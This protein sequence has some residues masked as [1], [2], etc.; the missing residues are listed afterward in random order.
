MKRNYIKTIL[1]LSLLVGTA[2]ISSCTKNFDEMNAPWKDAQTADINSLFNGVVASIELGAQEQATANTWIYPITQL[3]T[4]VSS[5][6]YTMQNASNELWENYYRALISLRQI[7]QMINDSPDK[8][9]YQN[10]QAMSNII[11]AY[12]TLKITDIFGDIPFS[13]AGLANLGP[14]NYAPKFDTQKSIYESQLNELKAAVANLSTA[15]DQINIGSSESLFNGDIAQ[16]K[17]FGNS[18]RLRYALRMHDANA[19]IA[20]AHVQEALTLPLLE[21]IE[22]VGITPAV[23]GFTGEWREWSF[24]AGLYLRMGSTAWNMLSDSDNPAGTGIFDPRAKIFFETNVKNEWAPKEQNTA[25]TDGGE[26]YNRRRDEDWSNKG[27]GNLI[28]N[29]N[30]YFGRDKN[31]PELIITAAEV[32]FLK[33]EAATKGI[34]RAVSLADAKTNYENGVKSSINF[35]T[36]M[37]I[38]SSV[39]KENKPSAMPTNSELNTVLANHKVAFSTSLATNDALKLIYTQRWLDNFRQ[40]YEAWALTRQTDATPKATIDENL[41]Q[42]LY[43]QILRLNYADKE[44]Q[45]NLKNTL[46]ATDQET[47]AQ[48]WQKAKVWWDVK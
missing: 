14:T 20:A 46:L 47:N 32:Y 5:S 16:W 19:S 27:D 18:L 41:Y 11:K 48:T 13:E 45:Y 38:K 9:K 33:A 36:S 40:P 24:H 6:G 34:G 23:Q 25:V 3:G 22:N 30:Y 37:A 28:S 42:N 4:I 26:P 29:F 39:W 43:G 1:Y 17:K 44:Y 7:D 12:K 8:A 35:W 31:I 10:I 21:N 15:S 2:G